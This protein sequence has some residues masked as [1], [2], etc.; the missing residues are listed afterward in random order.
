MGLGIDLDPL[1]MAFHFL[2]QLTQ[3]A[4][5]EDEEDTSSL[6]DEEE[7]E[8]GESDIELDLDPEDAKGGGGDRKNANVDLDSES[9]TE[10]VASFFFFSNIS[11]SINVISYI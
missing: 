8:N 1:E 7:G 4:S 2:A 9:D 5:L 10:K 11:D 3:N 6:V